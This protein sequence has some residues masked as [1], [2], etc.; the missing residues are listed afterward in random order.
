M[1]D[2]VIALFLGCIF[3]IF[4]G[5][6]PGIHTNTVAA[7][8]LA[9]LPLLTKWFSPLALGIMLTAMVIVHSFVDFIPSIFLGAPDEG[10]TTLSVLPGHALLLQ[11]RGYDALKLTIVGGICATLLTLLL[12]P[13][14]CFVLVLGYEKFSP[15]IPFIILIFSGFFILKEH[16]M[17]GKIWA[18]LIFLFSGTLGLLALTLLPVKEPLFPLLSSLFGI[19]TL[20][21][22]LFSKNKIVEQKITHKIDIKNYW[23]AGL[24]ASLS[25]A[26]MSVLPAM[27]AAQATILAQY[28]SRKKSKEDFLAT[29]G[30]INTAT[31]FFVLATLWLIGRART[32]VLAA[33]K[34]FLSIGFEEFVILLFASFITIPIA[35]LITLYIGKCFARSLPK[36]KYRKLALSVLICLF[37]LIFLF[38]GPI[39]ILI[40]FVGTA[41]GLLAP[42][43]RVARVHAMGCIAIPVVFYFVGL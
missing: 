1:F 29:V 43:T 27:G 23:G 21:I 7:S 28:A 9:V 6:A 11:G 33:M 30:G 40:S 41:I 34:Q 10:E 35:V 14:F 24:K 25:A 22:S 37:L 31:S 39:G 19:P 15:I 38:S 20:L 8:M 4:T 16:E 32:G 3:G 36:I 5:L 18:L 13:V 26:I 17:K 2:L 12:L 42:F